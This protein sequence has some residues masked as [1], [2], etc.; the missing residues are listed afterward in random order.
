M[1]LFSKLKEPVFLK[2]SRNAEIKL[3]KLKELELLLNK[4][5]KSIIRQDI[6]GLE[7]GIVGE[8]KIAF[9]LKNSH[10]PM[11]VLHD[12]YLEDGDLGA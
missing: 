3:E 4:D 1:G 2:E 7:Y 8:K 6:K 5:G 11:Y 9:E 10:M 12:I